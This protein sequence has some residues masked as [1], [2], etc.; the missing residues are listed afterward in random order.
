M[1]RL[2]GHCQHQTSN[3]CLTFNTHYNYRQRYSGR[4]LKVSYYSPQECGELCCH[5]YQRLLSPENGYLVI[6]AKESKMVKYNVSCI[7][8][9]H[10]TGYRNWHDLNHTSPIS[11]SLDMTFDLKLL[12]A[13]NKTKANT[14]RAN[15]CTLAALQNLQEHWPASMHSPVSS[16]AKWAWALPSWVSFYILV[17]SL[18]ILF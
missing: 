9:L 3:F 8:S 11:C 14:H 17:N 16:L 15:L 10:A 2:H 13:I 18:K 6:Q 1:G 4:L 7:F 5:L 12:I